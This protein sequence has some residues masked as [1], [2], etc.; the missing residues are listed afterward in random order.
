MFNPRP[1]S[2]G[3]G[4]GCGVGCRL[5]AIAPRAPQ[6]RE[7]RY[8]TG[9][10]QKKK[11]KKKK[12]KEKRRL[13]ALECFSSVFLFLTPNPSLGSPPW[14]LQL[15]GHLCPLSRPVWARHSLC[16]PRALA[17]PYNPISCTRTIDFLPF[18]L[19]HE[20]QEDVL[21]LPMCLRRAHTKQLGVSVKR[22]HEQMNEL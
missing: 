6:A 16:A 18:L 4:S 5:P 8:A 2:V 1:P 14:N 17:S 3:Q 15:C 7:P 13:C 21:Y 19:D 10:A 11:K 9:E 20:H 12:E 22:K